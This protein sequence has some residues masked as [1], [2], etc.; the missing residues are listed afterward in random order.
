[1]NLIALALGLG[2]ERLLTHL[3]HLRELR[4]LDPYF[5]MGLKSICRFGGLPAMLLTI[6]VIALPTAPVALAAYAIHDVVLGLPYVAFA[7]FVL[8]FS[9]GPRDLA[10]EVDEYVV[11][12]NRGDLERAERVAKELLETDVPNQPGSHT[13]AVEAAIFVQANNRV[14]GVVLWFMLLGPAGAWL[15]RVSDMLRRRATYEAGRREWEGCSVRFLRA[16]CSVHGLLAWLPSRLVAVGYALAGSFETAIASWKAYYSDCA[17]YF[18]EV[19]DDVVA[20]SG[21]GALAAGSRDAATVA[22]SALSLVTRTLWIW[23]TVIALMTL[24]GWAV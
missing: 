11:A 17:E 20:S 10:E 3:L 6:I 19:N 1:M 14:F 9:L 13:R 15:F 21:C 2:M 4:W 16:V 23:F 22:Q 5:D 24:F 12:L 18:F 7:T 8:I